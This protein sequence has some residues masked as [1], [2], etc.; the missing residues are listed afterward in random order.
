MEPD[1]YQQAWQAHSSQTR[2]TVDADLLLKEVQRTQRNFR[3]T[4]FCRDFREV[5]VALL[6][7]PLWFYMGVSE[8]VA[9]DVVS[10][11][12]GSYLGCRVHSGGSNAPQAEAE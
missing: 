10:H 11:G 2:V 12:A 1:K 9:L 8:F 5:G 7:M 4:I 3:A 6:L